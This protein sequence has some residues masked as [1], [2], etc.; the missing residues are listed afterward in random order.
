MFPKQGVAVE[1]GKKQDDIWR[2]TIF[3]TK[4]TPDMS[5]KV[6]AKALKVERSK[7]LSKSRLKPTTIN[8]ATQVSKTMKKTFANQGSKKYHLYWLKEE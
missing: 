2:M 1:I 4:S 3:P 6:A 5:G 7:A 8:G